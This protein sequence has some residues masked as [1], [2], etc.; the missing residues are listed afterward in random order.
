LWARCCSVAFLSHRDEWFRLTMNYLGCN[1]VMHLVDE[2]WHIANASPLY[3]AGRVTYEDLDR[4][5]LHGPGGEDI[6]AALTGPGPLNQVQVVLADHPWRQAHVWLFRDALLRYL[7]NSPTPTVAFGH[8][9]A[10]FEAGVPNVPGPEHCRRRGERVL[11]AFVAWWLAS[12]AALVDLLRERGWR[13]LREL[14]LGPL[15]EIVGRSLTREAAPLSPEHPGPLALLLRAKNNQWSMCLEQRDFD[16][17]LLPGQPWFDQMAGRLLD[18]VLRR[19]RVRLD[20]DDLRRLGELFR[21]LSRQSPELLQGVPLP[22]PGDVSPDAVVF[23][24][25][26]DLARLRDGWSAVLDWLARQRDRRTYARDLFEQPQPLP[27]GSW[28]QRAAL[29]WP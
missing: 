8:A 19:G 23:V 20:A 17:A 28:R 11:P 29:Y 21:W 16:L 25:G 15:T 1:L 18:A 9:M 26:E 12:S 2:L 6:E 3:V 7:G 5:L 10:A 22:A 4:W 14:T 27:F 24:G 13:H